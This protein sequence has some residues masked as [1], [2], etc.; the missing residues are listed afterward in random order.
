MDN[1]MSDKLM[2]VWFTEMWISIDQTNA[3]MNDLQTYYN[4]S[5]NNTGAFTCEIYAAKKNSFWMSPSHDADVIRIDIFWFGRNS[6]NPVAFYEGFWNLLA[7]Y[8]FRP[9]WGKYLPQPAD[10]DQPSNQ[11]GTGRTMQQWKDYVKSQ[12]PKWDQWMQLR[13]QC[14]PNQV[15]VNDYWRQFLDGIP[16]LNR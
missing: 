16:G 11:G 15:F 6:G 10:P 12:Y 1:Q 14:D 2:P 9:H 8:N 4:A 7:K 13:Q 5:P 3:V